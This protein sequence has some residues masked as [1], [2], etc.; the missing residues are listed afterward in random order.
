VIS[1][2]PFF[3]KDHGLLDEETMQL[4]NQVE[5]KTLEEKI[6]K[7][8]DE[9]NDLSLE[10]RKLQTE[11]NEEQKKNANLKEVFAI[12]A[13]LEDLDAD[14]R[15]IEEQSKLCILTSIILL[16]ELN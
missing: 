6:N 3:F 13:D 9:R 16:F 2:D 14:D 4:L 5:G 12:T 11:L 15:I 1:D 7:I 8:I 10:I